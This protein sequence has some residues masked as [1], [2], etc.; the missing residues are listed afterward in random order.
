MGRYNSLFVIIN[1]KSPPF[2]IVDFLTTNYLGNKNYAF[3]SIVFS[4]LIYM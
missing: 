3:K 2:E 4:K 1:K